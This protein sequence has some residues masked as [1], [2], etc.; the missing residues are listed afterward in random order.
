MQEQ[1]TKSTGC[2]PPHVPDP[3]VLALQWDWEMAPALGFH[4]SLYSPKLLL[5]ST[6]PGVAGAIGCQM[7][8]G[9]K[10]FGVQRWAGPA[11][12]QCHG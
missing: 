5:P 10:L 12:P 2:L 11:F 4:A 1:C 6:R 8:Q 3:T 9:V 7:K